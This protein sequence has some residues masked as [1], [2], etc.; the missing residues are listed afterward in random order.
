M[1]TALWAGLAVV[2]PIILVAATAHRAMAQQPVSE[3]PVLDE[4]DPIAGRQPWMVRTARIEG[5][6]ANVREAAT[7]LRETAAKITDQQTLSEMATLIGD[8]EELN[9][10]V[11]SARLAAEVLDQPL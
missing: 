7:Q 3:L 10:R 1:K 2:V 5:A 9:R 11:H 6:A 8:G 4:S